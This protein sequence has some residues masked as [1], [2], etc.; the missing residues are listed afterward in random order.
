MQDVN[1]NKILLKLFP[2]HQNNLSK[3]GETIARVKEKNE[4]T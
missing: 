3:L 2:V 1:I 4:H